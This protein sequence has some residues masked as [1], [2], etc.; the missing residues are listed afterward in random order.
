ME[1]ESTRAPMLSTPAVNI[2]VAQNQ[3]PHVNNVEPLNKQ[4]PQQ[5]QIHH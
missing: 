3:N 1:A 4:Q 5:D 2:N